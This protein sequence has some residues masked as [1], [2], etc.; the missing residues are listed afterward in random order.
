MSEDALRQSL[1]PQRKT[2]P[3]PEREVLVHRRFA[4]GVEAEGWRPERAKLKAFSGGGDLIDFQP[5]Y[6][7]QQSLPPSAT[8]IIAANELPKLGLHDDAVLSRT[9]VIDFPRPSTLDPSIKGVFRDAAIDSQQARAMLARLVQY[10]K[11]NHP[12]TELT[13]PPA[14]E[15]A[16][17]Q[18][19]A[20]ELGPLGEWLVTAVEKDPSSNVTMSQIWTAWASH[21]RQPVGDVVGGIAHRDLSSIVRAAFQLSPPQTVRPKGGSPGKGWKGLR[22]QERKE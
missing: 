1:D 16:V 5:K 22:L 13:P 21:C 4:L 20:E 14:V 9:L 7:P 10:A 15:E 19:R 17:W 12:G 3:T 6:M 18:A 2:G 11:D 8:I